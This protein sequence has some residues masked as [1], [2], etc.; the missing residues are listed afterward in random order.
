MHFREEWHKNRA[1]RTSATPTEE[2]RAARE[3]IAVISGSGSD[4]ATTPKGGNAA[5]SSSPES[6]RALRCSDRH[7][8]VRGSTEGNGWST[9]LC[10]GPSPIQRHPRRL[11]SAWRVRN[12]TWGSPHRNPQ[13][14]SDST[15]RTAA[16]GA[17]TNAKSRQR[18]RDPAMFDIAE[19]ITQLRDG[20]IPTRI[21]WN[22]HKW[23]LFVLNAQARE[24]ATVT[25]KIRPVSVYLESLTI[26][27]LFLCFNFK[28]SQQKDTWTR[29]WRMILNGFLLAK[30][31][32]SLKREKAY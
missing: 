6:E 21:T 10:K 3:S 24:A 1:L 14:T 31:V 7:L 13:I 5:E 25:S 15:G 11:Q 22:I 28:I 29:T 20:Y 23:F 12:S 30:Q 32:L 27:K 16:L 17:G 26:L 4:N 8:V 2:S 18:Q 19:S 9:P